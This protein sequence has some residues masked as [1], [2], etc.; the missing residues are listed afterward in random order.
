[1]IYLFIKVFHRCS[2]HGIWSRDAIFLGSFRWVGADARSSICFFDVSVIRWW[3]AMSITIPKSCR[4]RWEIFQSPRTVLRIV[5]YRDAIF[6]PSF[7]EFFDSAV[8]E[9]VQ[10]DLRSNIVVRFF[11]LTVNV[12]L[13]SS[14]YPHILPVGHWPRPSLVVVILYHWQDELLVLTLSG[15]CQ[16]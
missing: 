9:F 8:F 14:R 16:I 2:I 15:S 4:Q 5:E 12:Y 6:P 11:F 1:M 7:Q 3:T 10:S 13:N